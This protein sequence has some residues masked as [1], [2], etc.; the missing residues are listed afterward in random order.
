MAFDQTQSDR[1]FHPEV[2]GFL[3]QLNTHFEPGS[4]TNGL[5]EDL[6]TLAAMSDEALSSKGL[7]RARV[8]RALR[9]KHIQSLYG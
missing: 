3:K 8:E 1:E 4:L 9:R 7:T 5:R 2:P 6:E